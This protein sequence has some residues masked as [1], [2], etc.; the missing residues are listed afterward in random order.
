MRTITIAYDQS[1]YI[2]RWLKPMMAARK[3]FK[4]LR[5]FGIIKF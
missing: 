4:I 2:Y 5:E 1:H 3:E